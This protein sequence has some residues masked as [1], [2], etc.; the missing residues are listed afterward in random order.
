MASWESVDLRRPGV[1][2]EV[3]VYKANG[4][5]WKQH[6]FSKGQKEEFYL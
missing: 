4:S 2:T 3:A 1:R 6:N 5:L